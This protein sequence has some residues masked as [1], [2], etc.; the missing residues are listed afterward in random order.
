MV[1][2]LGRKIWHGDRSRRHMNMGDLR[3]ICDF[4]VSNPHRLLSIHTRYPIGPD[5][6]KSWDGSCRAGK[7]G[8]S[9]GY[10]GILLRASRSGRRRASRSDAAAS[11]IAD[12]A[13]RRHGGLGTAC[14]RQKAYGVS[15]MWARFVFTAKQVL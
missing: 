13:D 7:A 1:A 6:S 15:Q 10:V 5:D 12:A 3:C 11:R 2:Y 9:A 4:R 14:A 8:E